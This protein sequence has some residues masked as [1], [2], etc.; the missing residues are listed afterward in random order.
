M[1][2]VTLCQW[3]I[4]QFRVFP[5][6]FNELDHRTGTSWAKKEVVEAPPLRE[7][8]GE[9][10]EEIRIRG[11]VF[12][13]RIGGFTQLEAF[14]NERRAGRPHALVRGGA[15]GGRSLGW[16]I[17]DSLN[18]KHDYI[19]S[20]GVGRQINFEATFFRGDIPSDPENY[21]SSFQQLT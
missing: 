11:K 6:N 9:D 7:W 21:L 3:G 12:P 1:A 5:L 2:N 19:G 10:D 20:E 8:T 16:F 18:R 13:Y 14:D 17:C 15:E 4:I